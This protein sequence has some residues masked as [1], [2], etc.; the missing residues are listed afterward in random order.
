MSSFSRMHV[1]RDA[2]GHIELI[3]WSPTNRISKETEALGIDALHLLAVVKVAV[4]VEGSHDQ[5]ILESLLNSG[6][7]GQYSRADILV[8]PMRGHSSIASIADSKIWMDFIDAKIVAVVDNAKQELFEGL[9]SEVTAQ[10]RTGRRGSQVSKSIVKSAQGLNLTNE[11]R[12]LFELLQRAIETNN[13]GR[14]AFCGLSKQDIIEYLP[15]QSFDLTENWN[16]LRKEFVQFGAGRD[17]KKFLIEDKNA[18]I[19]SQ[20]IQNGVD[21]LDEIPD[22]LAQIVRKISQIAR[23]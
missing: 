17:F 11:E 1:T 18:R 10:L 20:R 19:S 12:S 16:A 8:I 22:D 15:P 9:V 6:R 21:S 14:V 5:I 13:F 7:V 2:K 3:Q 4:L 23:G